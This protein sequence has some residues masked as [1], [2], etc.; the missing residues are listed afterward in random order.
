MGFLGILASNSENRST[1]YTGAAGTSFKNYL[2]SKCNFSLVHIC[3]K[4]F[5][6]LSECRNLVR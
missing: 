3:I 6:F 2:T 5:Q 4:V 1:M